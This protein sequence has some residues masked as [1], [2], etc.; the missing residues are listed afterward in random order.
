MTGPSM[1]S[2]SAR[3][4]G[5]D[6]RLR[7][8]PSGGVPVGRIAPPAQDAWWLWLEL[9]LRMLSPAMDPF[10]LSRIVGRACTGAAGLRLRA[11]A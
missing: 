4:A 8:V 11:I 1:L 10:E 7:R 6:I 3:D 5:S 2:S 9:T